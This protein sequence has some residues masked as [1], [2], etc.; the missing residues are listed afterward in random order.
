MNSKLFSINRS[1][2]FKAVFSAAGSSIVAGLY[3]PNLGMMAFAAATSFIGSI[4]RR[5]VTNSEGKVGGGEKDKS[6]QTIKLLLI[7]CCVALLYG[8]TG[9]A[10]VP[11]L[12]IIVLGLILFGL[13][14][15]I[16]KFFEK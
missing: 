14:Y 2:V 12:G 1:D 15:S 3:S 13:L 6:N 7:A 8:C 10:D 9:N 5:F 11:W 4:S 16:K